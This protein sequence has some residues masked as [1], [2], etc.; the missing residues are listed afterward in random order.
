M[1]S[2]IC[3]EQNKPAST[4]H[5]TIGIAQISNK[6]RLSYYDTVTLAIQIV[7]LAGSQCYIAQAKSLHLTIPPTSYH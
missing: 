5:T 3:K 2:G 6:N 4:P 7:T 1:S